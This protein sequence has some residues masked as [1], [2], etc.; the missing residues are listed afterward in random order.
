MRQLL[1]SPQLVQGMKTDDRLGS[2]NVDANPKEQEE[3][4][5][6]VPGDVDL[7]QYPVEVL[8]AVLRIIE[9]QE[10]KARRAVPGPRR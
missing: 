4:R 6:R 10:R 7:D 3:G 8:E 9:A 1:K 5:E 2:Q